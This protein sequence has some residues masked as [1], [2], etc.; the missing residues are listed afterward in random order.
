MVV[1]HEFNDNWSVMRLVDF[2]ALSE[3]S[4]EKGRQP[5]RG[6]PRKLK[7]SRKILPIVKEAVEGGLE[8]VVLK[9]SVKTVEQRRLYA[10]S[11]V[12]LN[13]YLSISAD[14]HEDHQQ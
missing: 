3:T 5:V 2:K 12:D 8:V 13:K 9:S 6:R 14:G 11:S 7:V 1:F 10:K 4:L